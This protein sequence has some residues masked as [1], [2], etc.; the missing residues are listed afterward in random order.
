MI[1]FIVIVFLTL[2]V[3]TIGVS[4]ESLLEKWSRK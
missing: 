4:I 3:T 2:A 1:D